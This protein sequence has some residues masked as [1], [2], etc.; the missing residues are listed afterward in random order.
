MAGRPSSSPGTAP[1][2]APEYVSPDRF[3]SYAYQ[4]SSIFELGPRRVLE[5]GIGP[6]IVSAYL[7]NAGF[8]V[9][10]CD[11]EAGL[12]PDCTGDIR[13]LPFSDGQFDVVA[14]FEVLEHMSFDDA[15]KALGEIRR[16]S[17]AYAVISVPDSFAYFE[18]RV[19]FA[20]A[21]LRRELNLSARLPYFF[22]QFHPPQGERAL[23]GHLDHR[24]EMGRK[25]F[26]RAK[27]R[28]L[29]RR[30]FRI[31]REFR[32]REYSGHYFFVLERL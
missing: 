22:R 9:V 23:G 3:I 29:L 10:A 26:S 30:H 12:H 17:N 2:W 5:V 20:L 15:A 28:A 19:K 14:A 24:W 7:R 16:V 21:W 13:Q 18:V 32:P 11:I 4:L 1:Y 27:V 25:G 31:H 6:G 8:E